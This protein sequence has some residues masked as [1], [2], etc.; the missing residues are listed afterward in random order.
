M[1]A[2]EAGTTAP[3]VSSGYGVTSIAATSGGGAGGRN[4]NNANTNAGAVDVDRKAEEDIASMSNDRR[5]IVET[6]IEE[7][8]G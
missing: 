2:G 1:E 6:L 5:Q 8:T 3:V 4:I 7:R